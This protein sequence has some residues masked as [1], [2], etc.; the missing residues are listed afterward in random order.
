ML[1]IKIQLKRRRKHQRQQ[2]VK[3]IKLKV[4]HNIYQYWHLHM[5]HHLPHLRLLKQRLHI[6]MKIVLIQTIH[7][8][9]YVN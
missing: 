2:P 8:K 7:L 3:I 4:N 6:T 9:A 1:K 5:Q